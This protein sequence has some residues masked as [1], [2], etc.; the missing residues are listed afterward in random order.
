MSSAKQSE[1]EIV[2][3]IAAALE[4]GRIAVSNF[5]DDPGQVRYKSAHNP[6]TQADHLLDELLREHLLQPG[7]GWFSEESRQETST[8][9][10]GRVWV[11]DPLDGTNEYLAGVAEW[12]LSVALTENGRGVAAGICNPKTGEM[13]LGSATAGVTYN[14]RKV[15]A[16]ACKN[17]SGATVLASRSES[18]RGEWERFRDSGFVV[19]PVGSV[20]Y[21][22]ALVA[23]GLADLTW[24]LLP[25]HGWDVAAGALL[26]EAAGGFV[27]TPQGAA[28]NLDRPG[29][30]LPG[31]VAGARG[32]RA[33]VLQM[34][35]AIPPNVQ[36]P[37]PA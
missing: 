29:A 13:F 3:R 32:L 6:V 28:V 20:A 30:L 37:F 18:R 2:G 21:K 24:T 34:L 10:R 15:S 23:A 33:E 25:K 7:E 9:T 27:C 8:P 35:A 31:I 14:G 36:K 19:K 4:A 26:V 5:P 12:C 11:V 16:T 22:L 1:R 17:L